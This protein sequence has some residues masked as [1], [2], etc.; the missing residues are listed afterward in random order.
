MSWRLGPFS[1][2]QQSPTT[3]RQPACFQKHYGGMDQSLESARRQS[4]LG[5]SPFGAAY[6][7]A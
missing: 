6:K 2:S 1:D 4:Y 3:P 5:E 7:G